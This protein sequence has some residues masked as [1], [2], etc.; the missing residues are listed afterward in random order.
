MRRSPY[1]FAPAATM[2]VFLAT[3]P[4]TAS[5]QVPTDLSNA[6]ASSAAVSAAQGARGDQSAMPSFKDLFRPLGS[7]VRRMGAHQ[8]LFLVGVGA[9]S[10]VT[11]HHFDNRIAASEWGR[12]TVHEALVPG[13]IVGDFLVQ[14]GGAFATYAVG[15]IVDSPRVATIGA[16]LFR[17]GLI[18]QGT[19]QLIKVSTSRT[20]PDGTARSF[21][22]GHTA[23]AFATA[24]VLQ[25]ELGWKA[26]VPAY[27]VATWVA[28]SRV[29]TE[30]HFLSDVV[31]GAAIGMLAGRAVTFGAGRARFAVSPM[32]VPGGIG[33]NAVRIG[34]R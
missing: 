24:T 29:Q 13:K 23:S 28:A 22:S 9:A 15:R 14:T 30:R 2:A 26:G 7:D 12:G 10:A 19:T 4:G 31:A 17:A 34:T 16:H 3:W 11:A 20:R 1:T 27:A 18:S 25:A 8:E 5:G 6:S 21:P 33:V 32:V